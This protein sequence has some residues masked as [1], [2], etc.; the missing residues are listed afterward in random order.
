M[1]RAPCAPISP[2]ETPSQTQHTLR[3]R[4]EKSRFSRFSVGPKKIFGNSR[5][6]IFIIRQIRNRSDLESSPCDY[7]G[8]ICKR[9]KRDFGLHTKTYPVSVPSRRRDEAVKLHTFFFCEGGTPKRCRIEMGS[10]FLPH[11]HIRRDRGIWSGDRA[12]TFFSGTMG[13]ST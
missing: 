6:G 4:S 11:N 8:A 1:L 5:F 13:F 3:Y 12:I 10:G 9:Q 2:L 7:F